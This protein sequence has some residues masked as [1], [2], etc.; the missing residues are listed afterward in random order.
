MQ[1][2]MLSNFPWTIPNILSLYRLGVFPVIVWFIIRHEENLYA[3]ML[4]IS[5]VTDILDGLL[6]R[7]LNQRTAIG[8]RLDSL[9]DNGTFIAAF[10]G[11]F[12]FK[13]SQFEPVLGYWIAFVAAFVCTELLCLIRFGSF[14]S[15]HL[16]SWKIGGYIL[17]IFFFVLFAFGFYPFFFWFMWG[18]GM[19]MFAEHM[20]IQLIIPELRSNLKGLW[21]VWRERKNSVG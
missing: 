17:G 15:F 13:Y 5:L 14:P 10:W 21:W 9:A 16:Y 20:A 18:W 7:L 3:W 11:L 12:V 1:S 6:A 4:C 8:A 2:A 19:G